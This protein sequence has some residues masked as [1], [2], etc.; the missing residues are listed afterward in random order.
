M[1][2]T[3]ALRDPIPPPKQRTLRDVVQELRAAKLAWH[4]L[5]KARYEADKQLRAIEEKIH[6]I[7]QT[8]AALRK[9]FDHLTDPDQPPTPDPL[10]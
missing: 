9:E 5:D 4:N 3:R 8:T 6:D 7:R 1:E 10:E 2:P